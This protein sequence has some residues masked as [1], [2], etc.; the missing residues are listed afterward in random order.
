MATTAVESKR[1]RVQRNAESSEAKGRNG[2]KECGSVTADRGVNLFSRKALP[3]APLEIPSDACLA[4]AATQSPT[5]G[6]GSACHTPGVLVSECGEGEPPHGER[7]AAR[8]HAA[9]GLPQEDIFLTKAVVTRHPAHDT[10][11]PLGM[12]PRVSQRRGQMWR[13]T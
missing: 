11:E 12:G 13:S 9:S 1:T 6:P 8:Q 4:P 5:R 10:M 7:T 2:W 3:L